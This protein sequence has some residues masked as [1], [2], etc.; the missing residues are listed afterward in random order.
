MNRSLHGVWTAEPSSPRADWLAVVSLLLLP[1]ILFTILEPH[2]LTLHGDDLIQNY[3][4]R[5]LVGKILRSG[6]LP[7]WNAYIWSGTPLLAGFNAGAAYPLTWLFSIIPAPWAWTFSMA[8]TYAVA[9]TGF[10]AFMRALHRS[11]LASWLGSMTFS[12]AGFMA[13]QMVHVETMQ[14]VA[15]LTWVAFALYKT[16]AADTWKNRASWAT[17]LGVVGGLVIL[18]GSPEPMAYG[19]IFAAVLAGFFLWDPADKPGAVV[20]AYIGAAVLALMIGGAQ[21]IPG[22]AFIHLSQRSHASFQFFSSMSLPPLDGVLMLFPYILGGYN[23]F[24]EPMYYSGGFNLPEISGYV[25][26]L[27]VYAAIRLWPWRPGT[28]K[29]RSLAIFYVLALT[30]AVMALGRYTPLSHLF[31]HIPVFN[32]IRAQ[33]RNLFMVDFSLAALLAYWFDDEVRGWVQST[34][35]RRPS[36]PFMIFVGVY[37]LAGVVGLLAASPRVLAHAGPYLAESA[38]LGLVAAAG[39]FGLPRFSPRARVLFFT[40]LT[41]VD[42]GLFDGGQ[43]WLSVPKASVATGHSV[44]AADAVRIAGTSGRIGIYNPYLNRYPEMDNIG[45]P[46]LNVLTGLYSFQGYGSLVS[47]QYNALTGAHLQ[48]TFSPGALR[49]NIADDLNLRTLFAVPSSFIRRVG[50]AWT[51]PAGAHLPLATAGDPWLFGRVLTVSHLTLYFVGLPPHGGRWNVGLIQTGSSKIVWSRAQVSIQGGAVTLSVPS[52][53]S[54]AG[55][56][57]R[58][59]GPALPQL[60]AATVMDDSGAGS[61][62]PQTFRIYG[63]LQQAMAFPQWQFIGMVGEFGV[64]RNHGARGWVWV[65]GG[66]KTGKAV[67]APISLNGQQTVTVDMRRPGAL[68]RSETYQPGWTATLSGT[69]GVVPIAVTADGPVQEVHVPKGRYR[70]VFRYR[71]SSVSHGLEASALGVFLALAAGVVLGAKRLKKH[72][73]L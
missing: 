16:A 17:F 29:Y 55:V 66:E 8:V 1:A 37:V 43:Y 70:I 71:P 18:V 48:A 49:P 50:S 15:W 36:V 44:L 62:R 42:I 73:H 33:N 65:E 22:E 63:A 5:I 45:Q 67:A 58:Y 27:P 69:T 56:A 12:Y 11:A 38:A 3:P 26:L 68:I 51:A 31:Y 6:H 72:G 32:G 57:L 23:R 41:M 24:L 39:L 53:P 34:R 19:A 13:A 61:P 40:L 9:A 54:C 25:G 64:F 35:M 60:Q 21:W 7:L 2:M 46:D 4:L 20:L 14:G 52:H 10:Y 30:G 28:R 59:R 47:S